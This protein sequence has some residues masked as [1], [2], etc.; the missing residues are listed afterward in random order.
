MAGIKEAKLRNLYE[1]AA[2]PGL[3]VLLLLSLLL[4]TSMLPAQQ[5]VSV[6]QLY[7]KTKADL[8]LVGAAVSDYIEDLDKAPPVKT[9][10][11]L[12]DHDIGN[13]LS[14]IQFYM[15]EIPAQKIPS[16]D[17]WGNDFFYK[18]E[19]KRFWLA[20]AGSN[21]NFT[22]FDKHGFYLYTDKEM[23]GKDIIVSN[24][25]LVFAPLDAYDAI[26]LNQYARE[27]FMVYAAF[28]FRFQL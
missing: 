9:Y 1:S 10:R 7:E 28:A 16:K 8:L 6:R 25:G 17:A 15:D 24:K 19:G 18:A 21:G 11:E 23:E 3:P 26:R 2:R 20:S 22:G 13:G 5:E 14:F 4:T 27:I 12:L